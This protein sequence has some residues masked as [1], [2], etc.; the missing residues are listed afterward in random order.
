MSRFNLLPSIWSSQSEGE[1]RRR[2]ETW[3]SLYS[4]MVLAG[5]KYQI[6]P[7]YTRVITPLVSSLKRAYFIECWILSKL[8]SKIGDHL[9]FLWFYGESHCS[10]FPVNH[11]CQKQTLFSHGHCSFLCSI[12]LVCYHLLMLCWFHEIH[13]P[14]VSTNSF[15]QIFIKVKLIPWCGLRNVLFSLL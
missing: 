6:L 13:P 12:A 3:T 15:I 11:T 10:M 9:A 14:D 5:K 8:I 4:H 2:L 1:S 7:P